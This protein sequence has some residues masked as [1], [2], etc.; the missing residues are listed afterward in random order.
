MVWLKQTLK[1]G[2]K[3]EEVGFSRRC[4]LF[5]LVVAYVSWVKVWRMKIVEGN[6]VECSVGFKKE[7]GVIRK[8][9][10]GRYWKDVLV[11]VRI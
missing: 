4:L 10:N 7:L 1:E 3:L 6:K 9:M 8:N 2:N 5:R 11:K